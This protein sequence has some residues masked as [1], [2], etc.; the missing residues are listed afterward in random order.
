MKGLL[1]WE[2]KEKKTEEEEEEDKKHLRTFDE[3]NVTRK[4][5]R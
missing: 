4:N 2:D 3:T 5:Q 1:L